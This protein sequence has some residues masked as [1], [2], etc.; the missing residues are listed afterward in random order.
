MRN[1]RL[2][3]MV[4][5]AM[6]G[7]MAFLLMYFGEVYVPPFAEFLKYDPG[8]IPAMV[9][10]FTVG[11]WAGL[12][13]QA[14]KALLFGVS[15]KSTAGWIGILANFFAGGG[16]VLGA[17]LAHKLLQQSGLKHW[18]WGLLS[19]AIGTVVMAAVMIPVNALLVYPLWGMKGAAAWTGALTISTPFNLFKG[20]LSTSLT[21]AF[22]RRLAPFMVRRPSSSAA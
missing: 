14:I 22:Y 9:T 2:Y 6:M 10:T 18:G 20:M 1:E 21:L 16:L 11:P 8:D 15:G 17:G 12:A 13:V 7:A 5:I 4:I 3:R 19:A